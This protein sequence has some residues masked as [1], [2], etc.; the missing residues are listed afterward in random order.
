MP[1]TPS[2][3]DQLARL[4]RAAELADGRS[5]VTR[6][7]RVVD[8]ASG[9]LALTSGHT[10]VALAGATGSGK[11]SLF[12]AVS[13][14]TLADAGV[15]RPTT[16][17]TMGASFDSDATAILD[18]L[19]VQR[20]QVVRGG[21]ERFGGL[22]L[23]DLPDH[24]S[25]ERAHRAEVE[26]L[27][28]VVDALVWV[29]DPQKYAD[30][31]LHHDFLRPLAG[32]RDIITVALNQIDTLTPEGLTRCLADL[33]RI[34]AD[35]GLPDVTILATSARTGV[36]VPE[37]RAEI[38]RIVGEKESATRRL[39]ADVAGASADL[40][41]QLGGIP[42]D[43]LTR[44]K[45][46]DLTKVLA[47]AAGV[48]TVVTAVADATRHRGTLATGW[49]F[50][51]WWRRF[52]PDPLRRLRL[53]VRPDEGPVSVPRTSL[54]KASIASDARVASAVRLIGQDA[55]V[56]LPPGWRDAVLAAG[57]VNQP[58]LADQL[59]AAIAT[60]D[61]GLDKGSGWWR[62]V[63]GLQW[64]LMA[65]VIVGLGWLGLD[66]VLRYFQ[67]PSVP[68]VWIGPEGG[69]RLALPTV[70]AIGGAVAGVL[71]GLL[72]RVLIGISATGAARRA[73]KSLLASVLAVAERE[74]L[75]PIR[76]EVARH[77]DAVRT[78]RG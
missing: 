37:M 75:N 54:P 76:A 52:R 10:V 36:G 59:D 3:S 21:D 32:H 9:R 69:Y 61:L 2:L 70:L 4:S 66:V 74:V 72:S 15:L 49:P 22:V 68:P 62:V 29:V 14:T 30:A 65:S 46:R 1:R 23:L 77:A 7:R 28:Q 39:Q 12:N 63:Q 43:T 78:L 6:A 45:V 42:D 48:D 44:D 25:T 24:D 16:A 50:V 67:L 35:E 33:R 47:S 31:A 58:H 26:R 34:L 17:T 53:G 73:R 55:S 60:T 56:G 51:S 11:S 40:A 41:A 19:D 5:D 64:L 57:R 27:V 13:G 18:W 8:H 20:R 38:A 71:L